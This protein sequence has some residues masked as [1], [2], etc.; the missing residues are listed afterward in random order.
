MTKALYRTMIG[1]EQVSDATDTSLTDII[2]ALVGVCLSEEE[3]GEIKRC[4]FDHD[5]T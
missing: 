5:G 1:I 3:A 2:D 4:M